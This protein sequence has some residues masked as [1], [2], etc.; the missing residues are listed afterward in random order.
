MKRSRFVAAGL[1]VLIVLVILSASAPVESP[2]RPN[3]VVPCNDY[4]LAGGTNKS[5]DFKCLN[6]GQVVFASTS[7]IPDTQAVAR[8][9]ALG[10]KFTLQPGYEIVKVTKV[11]KSVH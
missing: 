10:V 9:I 3:G 8:F 6:T 5:V 11:V 4:V 2:A 1:I 7:S